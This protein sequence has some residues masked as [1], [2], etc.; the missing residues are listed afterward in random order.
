MD[1]K[2]DSQYIFV[3]HEIDVS[4]SYKD[5]GVIFTDS[6]SWKEYKAISS[7]AYKSLCLLCRLF[8]DLHFPLTHK[9]SLYIISE[10]YN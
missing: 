10:L 8:K 7:K 1:R 3:G 4:S 2:F 9:S 5:L 6:L